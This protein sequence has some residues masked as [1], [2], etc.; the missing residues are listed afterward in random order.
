MVT[1]ALNE[2]NL[3]AAVVTRTYSWMDAVIR[4]WGSQYYE[5]DHNIY[6]FRSQN[7]DSTDM[8]KTGIYGITDASVLSLPG[9]G[10]Y[11][12]TPGQNAVISGDI[13]IIAYGAAS[14]WANS[15]AQMIISRWNGPHAWQFFVSASGNL[16][17]GVFAIGTQA[18][19][20]VIPVSAGTPLWVRGTRSASSG[21]ANFYTS[22]NPEA[23]HP[24]SVSW[25]QLGTTVSGPAGSIPAAASEIEVGTQSGGTSAP[26]IGSLSG[27]YLLSGIGGNMVLSMVPADTWAGSEGWTSV[28]T[29]E[30]W[31]L[32]G[33]ASVS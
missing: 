22:N 31:L 30:Q 18:A 21:A 32:N 12:S 23:T 7:Y 25:T 11:A 20:S 6:Q 15:H 19:T 29:G 28:L 27:V 24:L 5:P 2:N 16:S 9:L 26:F 3:G 14:N 17:I 8:N 13:D 4:S 1:K 10:N 33:N